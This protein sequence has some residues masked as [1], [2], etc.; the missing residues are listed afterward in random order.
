MC[1]RC[2]PLLSRRSALLGLTALGGAAVLSGCGTEQPRGTAATQASSSPPAPSAPSPTISEPSEPEQTPD[3]EELE[4]QY[5]DMQAQ[6]WG[7]E[8]SGVTTSFTPAG[9]E[10]VL[11]LDACGGPGSGGYDAALI[12]YLRGAGIPATLFINKRWALENYAITGELIEDPL[13]EVANHGT[14]HKPLSV[15]GQEAYGIT[16]TASLEEAYHEV[17][18]NQQF[19]QDSFGV[20]LAFFRAGT[21]YTDE[22]AAQMAADLGIPV[23]NFSVNGDAGATYSAAEIQ[24]AMQGTGAGDIVIGHFNQPGSEVAVGLTAAVE[25][26]AGRGI[27]WRTLGEVL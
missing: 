23:V 7:L 24:S 8:T 12:D 1:D 17:M 5:G 11:T 4:A 3:F 25:E 14:E 26:A 27:E 21:A 9:R 13:F 15:T 16:G 19:F 22:I 2:H 20:E 18:D 10:A 6:E